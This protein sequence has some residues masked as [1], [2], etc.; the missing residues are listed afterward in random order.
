MDSFSKPPAALLGSA[1]YRR[2]PSPRPDQ[3]EIDSVIRAA[4]HWIREHRP[5]RPC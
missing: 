2:D 5:E 1:P 4:R 3:A